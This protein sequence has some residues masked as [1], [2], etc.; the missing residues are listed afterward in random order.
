M[1][2][3]EY[4]NTPGV[5]REEWRKARKAHRCS[6]CGTPIAPGDRYL[7][8]FWVDDEKD[9]RTEKQCTACDAISERFSKEHKVGRACPSSLLEFLDECVD[10]GDEDSQR[11]KV[12]CEEI[13]ER[14]RIARE[15]VP[16]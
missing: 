10:Y 9:P 5:W 12:A 7:S 1:C 15:A 16:S 2:T 13:R 4:D 8:V 6:T 3:V 11:W 14:R